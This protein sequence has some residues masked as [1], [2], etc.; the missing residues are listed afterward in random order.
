MTDNYYKIYK[1]KIDLQNR[2][3]FI[4]SMIRE[5]R[6]DHARLKKELKELLA[7]FETPEGYN[8]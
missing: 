4:T 3:D 8:H 1:T 2:I 5:N 7:E 6:I